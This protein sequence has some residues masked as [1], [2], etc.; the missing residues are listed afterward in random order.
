M[1]KVHRS[2]ETLA[3]L[4]SWIQSSSDSVS[5]ITEYEAC[6]VSSCQLMCLMSRRRL[7]C[8]H[9]CVFHQISDRSSEVSLH[10]SLK[11]HISSPSQTAAGLS[12]CLDV[13]LGL[14]GNSFTAHSTW[15]P[16]PRR[17]CVFNGL[18]LLLPAEVSDQNISLSSSHFNRTNKHFNLNYWL[19]HF[20]LCKSL[21]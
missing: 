7:S 16:S 19:F 3:S 11:L 20:S 21:L 14:H 12:F 10:C 5:N 8:D 13:N 1:C 15:S 9:R 4:L 2:T 17:V 6:S 18:T